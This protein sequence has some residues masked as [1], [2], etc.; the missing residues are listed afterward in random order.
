METENLQEKTP[1]QEINQAEGVQT[2][3]KR[4]FNIRWYDLGIQ[5]IAIFLSI[6]LSFAVNQ[7]QENK[8]NSTL[9]EF[10][11]KQILIDLQED[12]KEL[13]GDMASYRYMTK[14]Y[15]FLQNYD[16]KKNATP[17]S[18]K[19]Y[20][21]I[22]FTETAPNINNLGFETLRSTGKLDIISDK[23][24]LTQLMKIYQELLPSLVGSIDVYFYTRRNMILPYLIDNL[25]LSSEYPNGNYIKLLK[26]NSFRMRLAMGSV[27]NEILQ[28]YQL[29]HKEYLVLKEMIEKELKK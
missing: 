4:I 22:F 18:I 11:L 28:R 13:E 27:T 7:C 1:K 9:E 15:S 2:P 20:S 14:G 29:T 19:L 8:K 23:K 25:E 10:Y 21:Q 26:I 16:W 3:Q 5:V 6:T 12:I 24:I 17:D